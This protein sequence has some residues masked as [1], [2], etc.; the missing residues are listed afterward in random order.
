MNLYDFSFSRNVLTFSRVA[1]VVFLSAT[2]QSWPHVYKTSE[3][4]AGHMST[5]RVKSKLWPHVYKTSE[6]KAGPHVY[7]TSESISAVTNKPRPRNFW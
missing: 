1:L 6:I 2:N 7:K 3:I 4:K 5:K